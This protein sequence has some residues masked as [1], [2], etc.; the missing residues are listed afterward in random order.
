MNQQSTLTAS[1]ANQTGTG[2]KSEQPIYNKVNVVWFGVLHLIALVGLF[3]FS[4][5]NL[6]ALVVMHFIT[7]CLGITLGFHRLLSHQSFRAPRWL[8]RILATCGTLALQRGPITWSGCHRIHHSRTDRDGD[9]HNARKGFWFSHFGWILEENDE[10]EEKMPKRAPDLAKDPYLR[11][12]DKMQ[13][14]IGL[15]VVFGVLIWALGG[16][17]MMLWAVFVRLVF[18]Y[19]VTWFINSASHKFGY[20]T[21]EVKDLSKNCWWAAVLAWGEGWHNNHHAHATSAKTG[22]KWWEIDVTYMI[23]RTLAFFGLAWNIKTLSFLEPKFK[24]PQLQIRFAKEPKPIQ[25]AA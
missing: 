9:P 1:A 14:A 19:H 8:T 21:F 11:F 17:E 6:I 16:F 4:W 23:I 24:K 18:S 12:L 10:L 2:T 13:N 3:F 5:E 7:T 15:Q 20:R 22:L 25:D